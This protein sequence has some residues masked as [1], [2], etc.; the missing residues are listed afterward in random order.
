MTADCTH[1]WV[2][3]QGIATTGTCRHCGAERA[4]TGGVE[5]WAYGRRDNTGLYG[6][7]DSFEWL[8]RG[9]RYVGWSSGLGR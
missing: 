5:D 4:F 2:L 3:G 6:Q 8:T 1:R 9:I 7:G